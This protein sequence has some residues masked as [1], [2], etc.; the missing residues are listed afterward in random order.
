MK[1][2]SITLLTAGGLV[3]FAQ[4]LAMAGDNQ[5]VLVGKPIALADNSGDTWVSAWAKTG[6]IYTPSND[7][8]GFKK[9][10]PGNLGLT[11]SMVKMVW[12]TKLG[13]TT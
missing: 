1:L 10:G 12:M 2:F 13:T 9:I 4:P 5:S 8:D 6:A 3:F 11:A 7:T